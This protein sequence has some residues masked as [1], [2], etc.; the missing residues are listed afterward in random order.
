MNHTPAL[1]H[2]LAN[3][4]VLALKTYHLGWYVTGTHAL[5]IQNF[6]DTLSV[7]LFNAYTHLSK[8]MLHTN[9]DPIS[10]TASF[11]RET[12]LQ[13]TSE[14]ITDPLVATHIILD[15]M[16]QMKSLATVL[17]AQAELENESSI[18]TFMEAQVIFFSK[19]LYFLKSICFNI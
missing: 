6:S 3:L 14:C 10:T 15:D 9:K 19:H 1:N 4:I 13:E 5:A 12:T 7:D 16:A 2:Y 8:L 18:V 17:L 11:A